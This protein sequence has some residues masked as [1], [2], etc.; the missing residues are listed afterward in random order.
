MQLYYFD[1]NAKGEPI[2]ILLHHA[3]VEFEDIRIKRQ[4]WL[5]FKHKN[6]SILEFG[7]VP[8]LKVEEGKYLT[9]SLSILRYLG[10]QYGYYPSDPFLAYQVDSIVDSLQ[11]FTA[12]LMKAREDENPEKLKENLAEWTSVTLPKFLTAFENRLIANGNNRNIVGESYTIADFVLLS[13][14]YN[15]FYNE[16]FQYSSQFLPVFENFQ[17]L[18]QYAKNLGENFKEYLENRP[19]S[20]F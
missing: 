4:D 15:R 16:Q 1:F 7:Q 19:K 12:S 17:N 9:Q 10:S 14:I 13:V 3:K 18:T 2:R 11:D 6:L 8:V 20:A 5:E